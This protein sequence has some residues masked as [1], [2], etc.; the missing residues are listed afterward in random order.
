MRKDVRNTL[1]HIDVHE[2]RKCEAKGQ[3]AAAA[4]EDRRF[5]EAPKSLDRRLRGDDGTSQTDEDR[6]LAQRKSNGEGS[7]LSRG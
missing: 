6:R 7:P 2:R 1:P 5:T 4:G 3:S